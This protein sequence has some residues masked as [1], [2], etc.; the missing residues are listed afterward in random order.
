MINVIS[1]QF[2]QFA[3]QAGPTPPDVLETSLKQ[4]SWQT[5]VLLIYAVG[6]ILALVF[7]KRS[8]AASVCSMIGFLVLLTT[9]IVITVAQAYFFSARIE[10][11]WSQFDIDRDLFTSNLIASVV[12]AVGVILILI[13]IFVKRKPAE[14]PRAGDYR[15]VRM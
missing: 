4:L 2:T 6:M 7:W 10:Q 8:P 1:W 13:A 14:L 9:S 12:R 5:P 11:H 3:W 15:T